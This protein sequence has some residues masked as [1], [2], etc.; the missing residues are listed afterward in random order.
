MPAFGTFIVQF[1]SFTYGFWHKQPHRLY[2]SLKYTCRI[3]HNSGLSTST[4]HSAEHVA[5]AHCRKEPGPELCSS[6]L[7]SNRRQV[8]WYLNGLCLF[9]FWSRVCMWAQHKG[10]RPFEGDSTRKVR[11]GGGGEGNFA[12]VFYISTEWLP[13]NKDVLHSAARS[14]TSSSFPVLKTRGVFEQCP[15]RP[16]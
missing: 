10:P 3:D 13:S 15:P 6:P 14:G 5:P 2:I 8:G 12:L 11:G 16:R 9:F 1:S 7:H 4:F